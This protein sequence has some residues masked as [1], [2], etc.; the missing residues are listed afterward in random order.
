MSAPT[1]KMTPHRRNGGRSKS[2]APSRY[3]APE[4]ARGEHV[5]QRAD[6]YAFGL[7]TLTTC[8]LARRHSEHRRERRRRAAEAAGPRRR[9]RSARSCR[10]FHNRSIS[11]SP[12]ARSRTQ[13]NRYQTSA[14]LRRGHR[15]VGRQRQAAAHHSTPI[16]LPHAVAAALLLLAFSP[17][18]LVVDAARRSLTTRYQS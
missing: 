13:A 8:S 5:D 14:E 2:S 3:M 4:Q 15:A 17:D 10:I 18:H 7:I 12:S 1:P 16:R 11:C 6:V 9:R